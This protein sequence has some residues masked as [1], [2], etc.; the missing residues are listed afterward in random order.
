MVCFK[1]YVLFTKKKKLTVFIINFKIVRIKYLR[2]QKIHK[3]SDLQIPL[4]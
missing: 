4:L 3:L 2:A 1:I